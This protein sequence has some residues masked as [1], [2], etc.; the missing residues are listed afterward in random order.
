MKFD[1]ATFAF[2]PIIRVLEHDPYHVLFRK[3]R[4]NVCIIRVFTF[5]ERVLPE[6]MQIHS[7][8]LFLPNQSGRHIV[9]VAKK[10]RAGTDSGELL[11]SV[12]DA[13]IQNFALIRWGCSLFRIII[14]RAIETAAQMN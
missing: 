8:F 1:A 4:V 3:L 7:C 12:Q 5:H 13:R 11:R 6:A 9:P 10:G 2:I 14:K